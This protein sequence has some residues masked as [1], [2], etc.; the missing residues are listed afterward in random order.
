MPDPIRLGIIGASPTVGWAHRSH[1]PAIVASPEFE[2]TGVCTTRKETAEEALRQY[3]AKLAF[4][5]YHE[6]LAHPDIDA[7]A[8]VL[9]VPAHFQ[10][11]KDALN[12]G[13]H[14]FTEWPLGKDTG[15]AME[16]AD[17]AR[18]K[19]VKTVVGLQ[20]RANPAI[21]H[22]KEL[23]DEGYVGEIISCNM[24]LMRGG[25]L[26]RESGRTWQRDVELG[27]NTLTIATGHSIDALRFVAGE[28]G[29]VSSVVS[30]QVEQWYES[31][32]QIM[33]DVTS[34]DNILIS[35][36]L[37][38]GAVASAHVGSIPWA[39]TGYT[40]EVYGRKGTLVATSEDSP[41]LGMVRVQGTQNGDTLEDIEIPARHTNV[42]EGM[43]QGAPYNVGQLY[44]LFGQ[45]IQGKT[46]DGSAYP[47]PDFDTAVEL[48]QFI[49]A[50]RQ[51]A[52][53][54][55]AARVITT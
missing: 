48:H 38:N 24:K 18:S 11:T 33:V 15:E 25:V 55:N 46:T 8:V 49:D 41:Q 30:T 12:A 39:G 19:G 45:A 37:A 26:E 7:V 52:K 27:A 47:Y 23:V 10:I 5:D 1:L 53:D 4:D 34:P 40:M 13:K 36:Q 35:G 51:S 6:M 28:F 20:A 29:Q 22:M 14:V 31:D 2:L 43:P 44:Y 17:L 21:I 9:R 50:I 42:L 32:T 16:L 3:G 54:G